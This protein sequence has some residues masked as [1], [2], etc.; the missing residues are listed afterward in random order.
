MQFHMLY[1]LNK[2]AELLIMKKEELLKLHPF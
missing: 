1:K 2:V